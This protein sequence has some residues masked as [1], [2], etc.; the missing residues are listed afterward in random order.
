[1]ENLKMTARRGARSKP[2]A[3]AASARQRANGSE[4]ASIQVVEESLQDFNESKN[5]LLYADSGVGKTAA[6]G[7]IA[8]ADRR[9]VFMSTERGVVSAKRTGSTAGLYRAMDWRHIEAALDKA[10][11]EL[12]ENDWLIPDSISR[13]QHLALRDILDNEHEGRGADI[14]TPQ[15]Q[16]YP[17]WW[18]MYKRFIDRM[19]DAKYNTLMISTAMH[20]EDVE[21]EPIIVPALTGSS[22]DPLQISN[23]V[24]AQMDC[25]FYLGQ[26]KLKKGEVPYRRILTQSRPPY[27]AKNR[28][29]GVIPNYVDYDDGEFDIMDWVLSQLDLAPGSE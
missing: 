7:G 17:K 9:A 4:R 21:G 28:Y 16:H 13:M 3:G 8:T 29:A 15:L 1:M 18:N 19:V 14:D 2:A 22:K 25:V 10:D 20:L 24:C 11:V 23:Y 26:P 27:F 6:A 5:V 12:G